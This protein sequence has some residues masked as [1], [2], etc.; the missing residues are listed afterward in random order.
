LR[1]SLFL[2]PLAL[3]GCATGKATRNPDSRMMN[4]GP[5]TAMAAPGAPGQHLQQTGP[6]LRA[7]FVA[8]PASPWTTPIRA[9]APV[10]PDSAAQIDLLRRALVERL[11][12]EPTLQINVV[13]NS[14]PIHVID[15]ATCP[16]V[17]VACDAALPMSLDP[18]QDRVADNIPVPDEAWA[19]PSDDGHI[20]I[21]D[22]VNRVA[23]EFWHWRKQGQRLYHAGMG[24]K[25]DLNGQGVNT[26]QTDPY[27]RR[28]GAVAAKVPYI[29]GIIRYAE[30]ASGRIDHAL[31]MVVPTTRAGEFRGPAV[32]T[33]GR[34]AGREFIPEGARLQL[35]PGLDLDALGL[36]PATRVIARC[37][38]VYG[39]VIIDTAS[40][41]AIKAENL[42]SDGGAWR[43][44]AREL[45]L[46]RIPIDKF[47]VLE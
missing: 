10:D 42:G 30:M 2:I 11:H 34:R 15:P 36:T 33:D 43:Q 35:D 27:F 22:P 31:A 45:N 13:R 9:R 6:G 29:A 39:A 40:G 3:F 21:V 20:I 1:T 8:F 37:L 28:N 7:D 16:R 26:P 41:W 12:R 46:D 44:Y 24:G 17:N 19:D 4:H 25:W 38:Q 5:D 23:Y 47:R 32:S 14:A 18:D